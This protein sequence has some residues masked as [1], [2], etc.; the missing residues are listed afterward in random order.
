[1]SHRGAPVAFCAGRGSDPASSR[2][3]TGR[4]LIP[5]VPF[6]ELHAWGWWKLQPRSVEALQPPRNNGRHQLHSEVFNRSLSAKP[7]KHCP[8][9]SITKPIV[10]APF[11][12]THSADQRARL[13]WCA[14]QPAG[15]Q[16]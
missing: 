10:S 2:P 12:S 4:G 7:S 1:M 14:S 9:P 8:L 5:S 6:L 13:K 16:R 3:P 11:S 15:P